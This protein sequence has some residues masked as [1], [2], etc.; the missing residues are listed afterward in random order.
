MI[1]S[2]H[3]LR[4]FFLSGLVLLLFG[5]GACSE[6]LPEDITRNESL[7]KSQ[8]IAN[9]DFTLE[10]IAYTPLAR[11]GPVEI[12][13][14]NNKTVAVTYTADGSA[15][16]P[17]FFA[18]V[19]TIAK[20]FTLI[21]DSHRKEVDRLEVVYDAEYGLPTQIHIVIFEDTPESENT[22]IITDFRII[23]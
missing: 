14:R 10:R 22:Y 16:H 6:P 20:L 12:Q 3:R 17:T 1:M 8:R 11:R 7:W 5:V 21:K 2:K 9:Y 19:D 15:A 18:E 23:R 13:V 4:F